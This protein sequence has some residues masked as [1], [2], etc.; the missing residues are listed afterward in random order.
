MIL[1]L[2]G[3]LLVV[4][5]MA[6]A[7]Y[8]TAS[9]LRQFQ[10][11]FNLLLMPAENVLRL[12]LIVICIWLGWASGMTPAQFGWTV[13]QPGRD[14]ILGTAVG[15][16]VAMVLPPLTRQLVGRFGKSIYSPLVVRAIVP[17]NQR[18]WVLVPL[19][20][21]SSV[22]LEELLFRS[23]LLG[24]MSVIAP[25]ILLSLFWSVLFGAMHL[26]QGAF[27]AVAAASLGIVL[28]AMFLLTQSLLAPFV[29]HYA[30]DLLQLVAA[31]RD[32]EWLDDY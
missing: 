12:G 30:I 25:P 32:K 4:T 28:S 29:A 8:R 7:T 17:R 19:A 26:P 27:G 10:P 16:G 2:V 15:I 9:F 22:L 6:W 18:E 20:L 14:L 11:S 24:G 31:S 23:L 21:V 13:S 1:F 3:T 5:L